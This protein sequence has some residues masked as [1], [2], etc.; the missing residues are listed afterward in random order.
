[1]Y[2]VYVYIICMHARIH[3]NDVCGNWNE[4]S[5]FHHVSLQFQ[6]KLGT[7][8]LDVFPTCGP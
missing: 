2:V 6:E 3:A 4:H 5:M 8:D 1:M 7:V